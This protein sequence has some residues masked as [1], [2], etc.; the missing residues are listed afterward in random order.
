VLFEKIFFNLFIIKL[1]NIY[2]I[3]LGFLFFLKNT[4]IFKTTSVV[5]I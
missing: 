4:D 1:L 2:S 5:M 3:D